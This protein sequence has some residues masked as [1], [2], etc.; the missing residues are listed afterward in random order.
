MSETTRVFDEQDF[1]QGDIL[2]LDGFGQTST[3]PSYGI[4]I[5]ADCDLANN[6]TDGVVAILPV[7][8]F[9]R[10]LEAFWIP[11]HLDA[12][13]AKCVQSALKICG[14]PEAEGEAL[15][16]WLRE[17]DHLTA[18][19]ALIA[20]HQLPT[21]K[22]R[23]LHDTCRAISLL[24]SHQG[25][26]AFQQF[27]QT[28]KDPRAYARKQL[29]AARKSMGEGHF[30]LSEIAGQ[31]EIGFVVRMRRI[32]S[33]DAED[34]F[35]NVANLRASTSGSQKTGAR[36]ARL[37]PAFKYRVSQLFAYQFSRIGLP[38]EVTALSALAIDDLVARIE[39]V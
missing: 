27:C 18:S 26:R 19:S 33:L 2:L 4:V 15:A 31:P 14:I 22:H 11:N 32:L 17:A 30:F 35:R 25:F 1:A 29:D 6:K 16:L 36:I 20:T 9:E 7:Y 10:Y 21:N 37:S 39:G 5:N 23:E 12:E 24:L 8:T 34:C 38:D 13:L 3:A 28:Q